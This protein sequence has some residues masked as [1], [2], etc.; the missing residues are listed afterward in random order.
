MRP[1]CWRLKK[2]E[3]RAVSC[4]TRDIRA[5]R[6]ATGPARPGCPSES[7]ASSCGP[8]SAATSG[9]LAARAIP[10][11]S[12]GRGRQDGPNGRGRAPGARETSAC[13]DKA[14]PTGRI[15]SESERTLTRHHTS[16]H[17]LCRGRADT[18]V[19]A[20]K[21]GRTVAH[22][23]GHRQRTAECAILRVHKRERYS[24][25]RRSRSRTHCSSRGRA[26]AAHAA[27]IA[28]S[29]VRADAIVAALETTHVIARDRGHARADAR[30]TRPRKRICTRE[31]V[32][33]RT[34][35]A[36]IERSCTPRLQH[37]LAHARAGVGSSPAPLPPSQ[38][39]HAQPP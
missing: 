32:R 33:R 9:L 28:R 39:P 26:Q 35:G 1:P 24:T 21:V 3:R 31:C 25:R 23:A 29:Y 34:C 11:R 27:S 36:G 15:V 18:C 20:L 8:S 30:S 4:L 13:D 14:R 2:R 37:V 12:S 19:V 10:P 17:A 38:I 6:A 7:L 16:S 22:A 5:A